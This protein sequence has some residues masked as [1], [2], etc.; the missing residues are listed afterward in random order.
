MSD[1][2]LGNNLAVCEFKPCIGFCADSSKPGACFGSCLP[3]SLCCSPARA[4]SLS[5]KNKQT[6]KKKKLKK[7]KNTRFLSLEGTL[8][9]FWSHILAYVCF[10]I[11]AASSDSQ[12]GFKKSVCGVWIWCRSLTSSNPGYCLASRCVDFL[13][14]EMGPFVSILQMAGKG[15]DDTGLWK[16]IKLFTPAVLASQH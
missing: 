7:K 12:E 15:L 4:L 11:R 14:K 8:D 16:G 3:L 1:F 10:P 13:I 2:G 5:L 6:L 9:A